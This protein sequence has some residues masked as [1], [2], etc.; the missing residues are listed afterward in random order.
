[1]EP[2]QNDWYERHYSSV[3]VS[4][5]TS[6]AHKVM[7]NFI[8]RN[9]DRNFYEKVLDVGGGKA[10]HFDFIKHGFNSYTIIDIRDVL[11]SFSYPE[12]VFFVHG[13]AEKM[14]FDNAS[15]DRIIVTCLLHHVANPLNVLRELKR[16]IKPNGEISIMVPHDPGIFYRT[17]QTLTTFRSAAKR[18]L[19]QEARIVHSLE[20]RNNF[21]SLDQLIKS[22]FC[23]PMVLKKRSFPF[24]RMFWQANLMSVYSVHRS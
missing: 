4:G 1:M 9:L 24:G 12:K 22:E 20:H 8:E 13:D 5:K 21:W 3:S 2:L 23:S 15:F 11:N 19:L 18:G 17:S 10:E 6:V 7:H 16:I 14:P